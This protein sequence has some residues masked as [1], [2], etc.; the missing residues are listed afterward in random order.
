MRT[1]LGVS[2]LVLAGASSAAP[3]PAVLTSLPA[4]GTVLWRA[5]CRPGGERHALGVHAFGLSATTE[6]TFRAGGLRVARTLQPSG[7]VWFPLTAAPRQVLR[8]VQATEAG[9]LRAVVTADFSRHTSP[10]AVAH[11]Y[12][13]APPRLTV[14]VFP[15]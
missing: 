15:R 13:Y 5:D 12:P 8:A 10:G 6:L 3:Q 7:T 1:A 9:R 14:D 4:I 2:L 11:C